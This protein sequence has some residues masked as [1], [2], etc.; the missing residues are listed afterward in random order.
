[1]ET[2]ICTKCKKE[3]PLEEFGW[4]DK[5]KGKRRADCK[6]CHSN[7]MKNIYKEKKRSYSRIK[8]SM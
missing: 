8:I 3:L 5:A 1:M 7:Y 6:K 4:R 2:K